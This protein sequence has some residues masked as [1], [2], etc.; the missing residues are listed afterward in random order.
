MKKDDNAN[1]KI[2]YEDHDYLPGIATVSKKDRNKAFL[3]NLP[4]S[5]NSL[6]FEEIQKEDNKIE[7]SWVPK[8]K[9]F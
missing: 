4:A 3:N 8:K 6:Q 9:F 5:L 1:V 7:L 2:T